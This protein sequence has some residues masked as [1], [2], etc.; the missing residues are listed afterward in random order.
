MSKLEVVVWDLFFFCLYPQHPQFA[1]IKQFPRITSWW[2]IP[3][4]IRCS[5]KRCFLVYGT[6]A[7]SGGN[8]SGSLSI[9]FS[10]GLTWS[11][12]G[13]SWLQQEEEQP[14]WGE[15]SCSSQIMSSEGIVWHFVLTV[16]SSAGQAKSRQ[17]LWS[18]TMLC[19]R[20]KGTQSQKEACNHREEEERDHRE[21]NHCLNYLQTTDE[22]SAAILHTRRLS[23]WTLIIASCSFLIAFSYPEGM[24][25]L[26][27]CFGSERHPSRLL[28][29][30]AVVSVF[31]RPI[32]PSKSM[33]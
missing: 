31:I 8:A 26:L 25:A 27:A 4:I 17:H 16:C 3:A 20:P 33:A 21:A 32:N 10:T 11:P 28:L 19:S 13:G 23:C 24:K 14:G 2:F 6:L 30:G 9:E 1:K 29:V 15:K 12:A 5:T 18:R 22:P 7:H